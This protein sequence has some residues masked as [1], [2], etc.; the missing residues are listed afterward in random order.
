MPPGAVVVAG[1]AGGVGFGGGADGAQVGV[2]RA[3]PGQPQ[4]PADVAGRPGGLGGVGVADQP[5][6][7]VGHG[8]DV[9][10]VGRA[11]GEEGL[12]P[13]G[14]LVRRVPGGFGADRVGGVV[15]AVRLPVGADRGCLALPFLPGGRIVGYRAERRDGPGGRGLAACWPSRCLRS[16]IMAAISAR[17]ARRSGSGR[18]GHPFGPRA[19]RLGEQRVDA[20]A[21]PG[22]DDA[23]DVAGAGQVAGGDRRAGDLGRV[24]PG[25]LG[26]AQ[27]P[28]QPPGLVGQSLPVAGRERGHDQLAVAVVAGAAGFGGPD[29]VQD[30]EVVG[31]G[32]VA[33]P[34]LGGG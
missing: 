24:E 15:V 14:A 29:R 27:G 17:Y 11:E 10:P 4:F 19:L 34:G 31:V 9:R 12:V 1:L 32:Q 5:Q 16:S 28:E 25:Q 13:G 26:G 18:S 22:V 20:L 21:D 30:A 8:A 33:P 6:P 2:G 23:G 3:E 7:A